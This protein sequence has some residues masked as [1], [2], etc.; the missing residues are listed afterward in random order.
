[1]AFTIGFIGLGVMGGPMAAN[2]VK[3]CGTKV[4]GYDVVP[5]QLEAFTA[6]GG[7]PVKDPEEIYKKCDVILQILPTHPII[8]NSI[9]QII[10][11]GKKGTVIVD[12]SSTSPDIIRD[13]YPKVKSAGMALLDS[14]VSGGNIGAKQGNLVIMCGGDEATFDKVKP[15]LEYMGTCVTYM[16]GPGCGDVA[17]IANNMIVGCNLLAVSEAFA[18]ATKA[19]L[20]PAKLFGA[21]KDGFAQ[22]RVMDVKVPKLLRRDFSADARIA[23]H[24]KDIKNAE[25]LAEKL[26][27][28][29][30]MTDVVL[31]CMTRMDK[32]GLIDEDQIALVKPYEKDMG[33]EV[34]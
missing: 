1:M 21:I 20:D 13:L 8:I 11:H 9:E 14:P 29:L 19:G 24:Y 34:K 31:N 32:A 5:P 4:Y 10:K 26:G 2:I 12:M 3:K 30:P 23:V 16:G 6:I 15:V 27:V 25:H 7:T 18:L 22:N 33:V 17:K 28:K